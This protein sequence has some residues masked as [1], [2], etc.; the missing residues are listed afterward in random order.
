MVY[1]AQKNQILKA[2]YE[3]REFGS[4][5]GKDLCAKQELDEDTYFRLHNE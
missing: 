5:C 3:G 2:D 1:T 4:Y